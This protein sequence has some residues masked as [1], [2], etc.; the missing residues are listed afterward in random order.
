M[1]PQVRI[2]PPQPVISPRKTLLLLAAGSLVAIPQPQVRAEVF[3]VSGE[4]I[5]LSAPGSSHEAFGL[6]AP[7]GELIARLEPNSGRVLLTEGPTRIFVERA[8]LPNG[9]TGSGAPKVPVEDLISDTDGRDTFG[10]SPITGPSAYAGIT[11]DRSQRYWAGNGHAQELPSGRPFVTFTSAR[12]QP[13]LSSAL[14]SSSSPSQK[15]TAI[16]LAAGT[17]SA[18]LVVAPEV[19]AAPG[20]ATTSMEEVADGT[21][22][23]LRVENG[24]LRLSWTASSGAQYLILE[25]SEPTGPYGVIASQTASADGPMTLLLP[26]M[27]TSGFIRLQINSR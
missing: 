7:G 25:S 17:I 11:G 4:I 8:N 14:E 9:R 13:K 20:P 10:S 3:S 24:N 12:V 16:V 21:R 22:L 26:L 23:A 18:P 6:V 2:L 1:I 15:R 19:V 27:E 5:R